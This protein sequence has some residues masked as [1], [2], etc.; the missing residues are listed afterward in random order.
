M[1]KKSFYLL[2][3]LIIFS[4]CQVNNSQETSIQKSEAPSAD[5][6]NT[7]Q[8]TS[9]NQSVE[10]ETPISITPLP[11]PSNHSED[12]SELETHPNV[13]KAKND[14]ATRSNISF[15]QIEVILVKSMTWPNSSLGC[16]Q[17]DMAYT[18]VQKEGMLIQLRAD[19]FIYN[20]HSG[21]SRD[22]FLCIQKNST[23]DP[24]I[25]LDPSMARTPLPD[26]LDK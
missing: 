18:Q 11:S 5:S 21:E 16:P 24:S 10:S 7:T 19:G 25:K 17:P 8:P 4:G 12:M 22:P 20:Y 6:S 2:F 9:E 1:I 26:D 3:S 15:D 14:L 13:F 23:K